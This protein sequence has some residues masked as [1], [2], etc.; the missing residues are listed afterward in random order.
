MQNDG[1]LVLYQGGGAI[2]NTG[3]YGQ[4]CSANQCV[5]I[6]QSDGKLVVYN[7]SAVLW[8]SGTYGNSQAGLYCSATAP[9][10]QI[11]SVTG[12]V[13]WTDVPAFQ[14]GNLALA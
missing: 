12:S 5:A 8:S 9:H 14:T 7:G 10:L 1:N 13:L 6:F 2:W 4:D 11:Y 3:T